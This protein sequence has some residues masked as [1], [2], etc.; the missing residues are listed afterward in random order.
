M[1]SFYDRFRE[2]TTQ[3]LNALRATYELLENPAHRCFGAVARNALGQPCEFADSDQSQWTLYGALI[4]M[5]RN[6]KAVNTAEL[7]YYGVMKYHPLLVAPNQTQ[8]SYRTVQMNLDYAWNN[9]AGFPQ[10]ALDD[11]L[12][13]FVDRSW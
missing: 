4:L 7:F 10:Q 11:M 5:N 3:Q 12:E 8:V 6:H 1:K 9:M 13:F 2:P